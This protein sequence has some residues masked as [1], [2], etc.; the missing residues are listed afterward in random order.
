M[1]HPVL[2]KIQQ[3]LFWFQSESGEESSFSINQ[4]LL[5]KI[6]EMFK[7]MFRMQVN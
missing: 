2:I 3:N 6:R 5:F 4:Q 1:I 7:N